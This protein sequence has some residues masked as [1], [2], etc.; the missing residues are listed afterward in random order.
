M[1]FLALLLASLGLYGVISYS[2]RQRTREIGVRVALGAD[3]GEVVRLVLRQGLMVAGSG[4]VLGLVASFALTRVVES[5]LVGV[6]STDLVTFVGIPLVL[7][8]VA[9]VASYVPAR[10]AAGVDPVVALGED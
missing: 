8:G 5:F 4:V 9:L 10:R 6:E 3:H 1:P 7:L 2:V